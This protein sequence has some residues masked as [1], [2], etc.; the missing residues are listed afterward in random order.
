M[1][2]TS[3]YFGKLQDAVGQQY[4]P[5]AKSMYN[6]VRQSQTSAKPQ[7]TKS[8]HPM[9]QK[10]SDHIKIH[11]SFLL[12]SLVCAFLCAIYPVNAQLAPDKSEGKAN[13]SQAKEKSTNDQAQSSVTL[14]PIQT[15][16]NSFIELHGYFRFRGEILQNMAIDVAPGVLSPE[17]TVGFS[18]RN[19]LAFPFYY[20]ISAYPRSSGLRENQTDESDYPRTLTYA[21]MRLR[22]MLNVNVA[23][24]IQ[25]FSTM[26]LLDNMVLG[27]TP[28]SYMGLQQDP[29]A[30]FNG[31]SETMFPP[32]HGVNGYLDSI[33]VRHVYASI[34]TPMGVLRVGRMPNHW[35]LGILNNSGMQLDSDYGANVDRVMFITQLF[36]HLVIPAFDFVASGPSSAL[37]QNT[38]YRGQA[39]DLDPT[40]D[41]RQVVLSVA[42]I[43]QGN[44]LRDKMEDGALIIN[45]GAY[46]AYRWQSLSAEC[47]PANCRNDD[48]NPQVA[49]NNRG[50][51]PADIT[52]SKR[53][54]WLVTPDIWFRL[55]WGEKMRLE[56]E[57]V[58]LIGNVESGL[59]QK[60]T[61]IFQWGGALEFTYNFLD[62]ALQLG[63]NL[64]IASGDKDFF[65]RWGYNEDSDQKLN[66][67][68]FDPDYQVDLILW[69]EMYGSITNAWYTK[70]QLTYNF[71]GNPWI[72][73]GIGLRVAGIY[74]MAINK[75]AT[76]GQAEP[77]GVELNAHLRWGSRDGYFFSVD[78]GILFPL[79]GLSYARIQNDER[80]EIFAPSIAQRIRFNLA[81]KF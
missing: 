73:E 56:F 72:D 4:I 55:L 16:K 8:V 21:N 53:G 59:G 34:R 80:R 41:A 11:Y 65:S 50:R 78:Y 38:V 3:L 69:R 13:N 61:Q 67:F 51:S 15:P 29:Y 49:I 1:L 12:V 46:I 14:S 54:M 62:G 66:N 19:F 43:D 42:R 79:P 24:N 81:I 57:W 9:Y 71:Y 33:R 23:E 37:S 7:S 27:S 30:P 35:G 6:T 28:Q 25:I 40:D 58:F 48:L 5:R 45:Y 74:S 63:L 77:L 18:R 17:N 75:V 32:T 31:L 64:G 68:K 20:P 36:G 22:L 70:A 26:D 44:K 47:L 52:L 10:K 76:L 2:V 39:F 60:E